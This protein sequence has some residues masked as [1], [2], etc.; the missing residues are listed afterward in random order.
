MT[1]VSWR[2]KYSP[3]LMKVWKTQRSSWR[4]SPLLWQPW[5]KSRSISTGLFARRRQ[6][7]SLKRSN[8][9]PMYVS[10]RCA[11]ATNLMSQSSSNASEGN[12]W[13]CS[14]CL[15]A[16]FAIAW[17]WATL[18]QSARSNAT[19]SGPCALSTFP[20]STW[21]LKLS[22]TSQATT[23][24]SRSTPTTSAPQLSS[25]S[26]QRSPS[27]SYHRPWQTSWSSATITTARLTWS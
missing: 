5:S 8:M 2:T 17:K 11:K 19:R 6:L 1:L 13:S 9:G 18:T 4:R 27:R 3:R 26:S 14:R 15:K 20:R 22:P 25:F 10:K 24:I 23:M 16:I 7:T 12:S 21:S